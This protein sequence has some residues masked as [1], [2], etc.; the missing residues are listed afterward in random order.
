L[1]QLTFLEIPKLKYHRQVERILYE[2][3]SLLAA[4]ENEAEL[5]K[6]GLGNLFPSMIA[7]YGEGIRGSEISK[8]TESYAIRRAEKEVKV[9]QI[10]RAFNA[11]TTEEKNLLDKKY[12]DSS[13]PSDVRVCM[14]NGY[15]ERHYYRIKDRALR[16]VAIALNII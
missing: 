6:E 14:E 16:K 9:K 10:N 1:E 15:S 8:P 13:Q 3:P 7:S 4:I 5:E 12:F 2:Y 11:L